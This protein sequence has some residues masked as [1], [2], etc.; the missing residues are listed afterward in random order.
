ME[1]ETSNRKKK[2]QI[3]NKEA[4]WK[5][6]RDLGFLKIPIWFWGFRIHVNL[7]LNLI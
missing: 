7:N 2:I 6:F 1:T 3:Q 5:P 4:F